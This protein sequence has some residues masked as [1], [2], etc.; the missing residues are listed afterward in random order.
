L[1]GKKIKGLQKRATDK[2]GGKLKITDLTN[3]QNVEKWLVF[4]YALKVSQH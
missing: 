1:Q 2:T 3:K 4:N